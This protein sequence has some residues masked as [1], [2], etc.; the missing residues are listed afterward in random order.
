MRFGRL[1]VLFAIV[2]LSLLELNGLVSSR[3]VGVVRRQEQNSVSASTS[4]ENNGPSPTSS[5]VAS[6]STGENEISS[7][8]SSVKQ[9]ASAT[10]SNTPEGTTVASN[11]GSP[12]INPE[13]EVYKGGLPIKPKVTPG[14]AVAGVALLLTGVPYCL[15]GIKIKFLQIF[16]STFFL[17]GLGVTVLIVYVM[18]PPVIDA[19]QGA[20][21]TAVIIT[22]ILT[23]GLAVV[24]PEVTEALGCLLGGFC[25]SMWFLVLKPGGLVDSI[26]GKLAICVDIFALVLGATAIVLGIDCFSTAGLKEFW[27]YIWD[28]NDNIFPLETNTYP[29][30]RGIRV[31]IA[32]I[33]LITAFGIMSQVKLW[34]ILK[35]RRE[36]KDAEKR[37][38]VADLEALDEDVGRRVEEGNREERAQWE[39]VY[40]GKS[41]EEV[42]VNE[43]PNTGKMSRT[44]SGIGDDD[45]RKKSGEAKNG[46]TEEFVETEEM[47]REREEHMAMENGNQSA[48][49]PGQQAG[50]EEQDRIMPIPVGTDESTNE[51]ARYSEEIKMR[52]SSQSQRV[53]SQPASLAPETPTDRRVITPTPEVI[54]LPIPIP[55]E[56]DEKDGDDVSSLATWAGESNRSDMQEDQILV[57][58]ITT[59]RFLKREQEEEEDRA[60]SL[61]ATLDE[62]DDAMASRVDLPSLNEAEDVAFSLSVDDDTSPTIT[63]ANFVTNLN[64][65]EITP[66]T[67]PDTIPKRE[68]PQYLPLLGLK[69][70]ESGKDSIV[71]SWDKGIFTG[72]HSKANSTHPT[73]PTVTSPPSVADTSL[74]VQKISVNLAPASSPKEDE[75]ESSTV[76][77][78]QLPAKC[79]RVVKNY[80]TNEWAKHLGDA[81]KPDLDEL[82]EPVQDDTN[83]IKIEVSAPVHMRELQE[84]SDIPSLPTSRA[85]SRMSLAEQ[86]VP[87]LASSNS[88]PSTA[89]PPIV[90]TQRLSSTSELPQ[91]ERSYTLS[92]AE[93]CISPVERC[94]SPPGRQ[95]PSPLPQHT[96]IGKRESMVRSRQNFTPLPEYPEYSSPYTSENQDGFRVKTPGL[97]NHPFMNQRTSTPHPAMLPT[98]DNANSP[99]HQYRAAVLND[100]MSLR[101]RRNELINSGSHNAPSQGRRA[102][103]PVQKPADKRETMFQTWRDNLKTDSSIPNNTIRVASGGRG[104][105]PSERQQHVLAVA[106]E[107]KKETIIDDTTDERMRQKDMLELHREA[108]RRMQAGANKHIKK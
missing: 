59:P 56:D 73:T 61:A 38:Q 58:I 89:T 60:S 96:L 14:M 4:S 22:G 107:R 49:V 30:T 2:A 99:S 48:E 103:S 28:L 25:V 69:T 32:V 21:V 85:P 55:M 17:S 106:A 7:T 76:G 64:S 43:R 83:D 67:T 66:A 53:S 54:P 26:Y 8:S 62:E 63:S 82:A 75:P 108:L 10:V 9:T 98:A 44:D 35:E 29:H 52:R 36:A 39:M 24:F 68:D 3:G 5:S 27:I 95:T 41:S 100:D 80:R 74:K 92:P 97:I 84:T 102:F 18:N 86:F 77:V 57:D 93:R 13:D 91:D 78:P 34:K 20:Y 88:F 47:R 15:I 104:E 81:E 90:R 94:I 33:I 65:L 16:L 42:T 12:N 40:G 45:L 87:T 6:S 72:D 105:I 11:F 71:S 101:D 23:G 19:I 79:S 46:E 31:E 1:F 50:Q 70:F 51:V 37:Q